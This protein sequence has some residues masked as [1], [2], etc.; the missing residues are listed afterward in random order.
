MRRAIIQTSRGPAASSRRVGL[1][2]FSHKHRVGF[3]RCVVEPIENRRPA[4]IGQHFPQV[5]PLPVAPQAFCAWWA[6]PPEA[7]AEKGVL[8]EQGGDIGP[9]AIPGIRQPQSDAQVADDHGDH[10]RS[11]QPLE[12]HVAHKQTTRDQSDAR[13][14]KTERDPPQD[15]REGI[16]VEPDADLRGCAV[17][18]REK[19]DAQTQR[20]LQGCS[21]V[22]RLEV[23]ALYEGWADSDLGE[24][25]HKSD[26]DQRDGHDAKVG[27]GNQPSQ[28]HDEEQLEQYLA[29]HI[30]RL[31]S[32]G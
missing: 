10:G 26:N 27:F 29:H 8:A 31:P 28:H 12:I 17:H 32:D 14:D 6:H 22:P 23:L 7:Q 9:N 20:E 15:F 5:G 18:Q 21:D 19:R 24:D 2:K 1:S 11:E 4:S 30:C 25:F 3:G 13:Q 16:A